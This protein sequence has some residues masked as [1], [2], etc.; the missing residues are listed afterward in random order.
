[1]QF[2]WDRAGSNDE[3]S[4]C[5]VRLSQPS[6]GSGWGSVY[7]PV[8]GNEVVVA[9]LDGD[10]DRPL[11]VGHVY[12]ADNM[13]PRGLPDDAVKTIIQDVAGNLLLLDSEENAEV[14]KILTPYK[15]NWWKIGKCTKSE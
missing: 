13:P 9:F 2:R 15:D 6:A 7:L 8:A 5:W 3:K 12:N 10:P 14:I 4:S 1:V 11:I